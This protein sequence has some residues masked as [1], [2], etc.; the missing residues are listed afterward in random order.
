MHTLT[1]SSGVSYQLRAG[2]SDARLLVEALSAATSIAAKDIT[3]G[4]TQA[5]GYNDYTITF[6]AT[7]PKTTI[8]FTD[9]SPAGQADFTIG[10]DKIVVKPADGSNNSPVEPTPPV[11]PNNMAVNGSFEVGAGTMTMPMAHVMGNG[12]VPGWTSSANRIEVRMN[13]HNGVTGTDGKNVVEVDAQNGVLSQTIATEAGKAYGITFDYAGQAGFIGSSKMEV[14]WNGVVIATIN[15]ADAAFKNY[16]THAIGTG[17]NDVLAFRAVAGDTD[18]IGGLLDK[19]VVAPS[20]HPVTPPVTPPPNGA[21]AELIANGDFERAGDVPGLGTKPT[22]WTT[23]GDG[24]LDT[25]P[26]YAPSG[27]GYYALGGWSNAAGSTLQQTVATVAGQTYTLTFTSGL[28]YLD[29]A[30]PSGAKLQIDAL[31]GASV[32]QTQTLS[33]DPVVGFATY[34][35][36]FVATGTNSTIRFKDASAAGQGNFDIGIDN[37]SVKAGGT[38]TPPVSDNNDTPAHTISGTAGNDELFD[39]AANDTINASDG[40][41]TI[42]LGS[43]GN[44]TVDGGA[45][46]DSVDFHG[47]ASDYVFTSNADGTITVSNATYGTDVLKNIETLWFAGEARAYDVADLAPPPPAPPT[48]HDHDAMAHTAP[49]P[50]AHAHA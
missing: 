26:G 37:V 42:V 39:T 5:A 14:L 17:G 25:D 48:D 9:K 2:A 43:R 1:F 50:D 22:G 38:A 49:V 46:I 11:D 4:S 3:L 7:G 21:I 24:G 6:T 36:T 23:V 34:S 29:G 35:I 18:A 13:G 32:L 44:D 41:D 30:L 27:Q 33:F 10:L 47:S 8:K 16:H 28:A 31:N 45:G 12:Q 15:P 19:V 20:D 40:N